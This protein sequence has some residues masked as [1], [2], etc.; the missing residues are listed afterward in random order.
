M[1]NQRFVEAFRKTSSDF[2]EVCYQL[3]GYRIDGLEH[4]RYR[5]SP[6]YAEN[7]NDYLLFQR[8]EAGECLLLETEFSSQLQEFIDLHLATQNSIPVFLAAVITDLF[9]RQTF[10]TASMTASAFASTSAAG[11]GEEDE[12]GAGGGG[13]DDDPICIDS[14]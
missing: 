5:L 13:D 8:T 4:Q 6:V 9:S 7:A 3:T 11:Q 1:R 12:A 2:R 14:D 10:E